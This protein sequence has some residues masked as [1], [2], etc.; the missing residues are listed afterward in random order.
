MTDPVSEKDGESTPA[1]DDSPADDDGRV[2]LLVPTQLSV[3]LQDATIQEL[4]CPAPMAEAHFTWGSGEVSAEQF[5]KSVKAAYSEVVH[6]RRN[7]F[8]V[9]SGKAGKAFVSEMAWLFRSYAEGSALESIAIT[10]AMILPPLLLQKPTPK[11]KARDHVRCLERRLQCWRDGDIESLLSEGKTIQG[12]LP[13]APLNPNNQESTARAFAKLMFQGKTKAALRLIT[14]QNVGSVL[15]LDSITS[16]GVGSVRDALLSKHPPGRPA[17]ASALLNT[18]TEPPDVHPVVFEA[19]DATT[20]KTAALRTDGAAGPSGIDARGWTRLCASFHSASTELCHSLALLARRLCS[21]YIHPDGLSAL[22]ACRLIALDKN[23]GVR[24]IGVGEIPRRIIAKAVLSVIGGEIQEAAGSIQLCSGQTSGIEAA[25]HAMK[26]AYE[27]EAVE[28]VLLVDAK[29]AFNCLNREAALRNIQHLCPSLA[30]ILINTYRKPSYLYMDGSTLLSQEGTTQGDPLAMSMYAIGIIPLIQ[31]VSCGVKQ[32]W[33]ADDATAAGQLKPIQQWWDNLQ[34]LGPDFGYFVNSSKTTLIVKEHHLAEAMKVFENTNISITTEGKQHLGAALG[35]EAFTNGF[36]NRKVQQW[37]EEV[38][39]LSAIAHTQPHAAY[40]AFIRGLSSKWTYISRTV[41]DIE[42][43]FQPLEET[44]RCSFLPT[45]TGRAP[46][47]ELERRLFALPCRLGG[48]GIANPAKASTSEYAASQ[49]VTKPLSDLILQQNPQYSFDTLEAQLIAKSNL[50]SSKRQQQATESSNLK[51]S[52][53][54]SLQYS[55]SLAQESGASS[56]L[57]TLPIEEFGFAL[58]KGAFRDALAL[59][60]GWCPAK[61]PSHCACGQPFSVSHALSCHMGGYPS[62]RHNEIRDLTAD[63]M[64]VVC[65]GVSTEPHLQPVDGEIL[66]GASA[67]TSDGARLDIAA[68]G[69][70][71]GRFERAFF[72]VRVFNPYAPTNRRLQP[73]T[74]YRHHENAKK[75]AYEQRVREIE[76]ASF[77]PLVLSVTGGLG[78]IATT[79]YKRLAS[80]LSSKWN[81][82]Y[83]TTMGWLRCRLSFALLRSSIAAIRGARSSS[84]RVSDSIAVDLV[85]TVSQVSTAL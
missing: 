72:D 6:W 9:P 83:S 68:N 43:L 26:Q 38:K 76:H 67:N 75:R 1:D 80:L 69:L 81:Q 51:S 16:G 8:S 39:H 22:L 5:I 63:L 32:V 42:E 2:D 73:A 56:W 3:D 77:V 78:R 49:Q 36:V 24:P 15:H 64:S 17:S 54:A 28:A 40:S 82:P 13:R 79:T 27:D 25:V 18:T 7:V 12:R 23:P 34:G 85:T 19:I 70:W 11:S 45:L 35:T 61:V 41:P 53:P 62:I 47:N 57:T 44:I 33:Y 59:R 31:K 48:I 66:R 14:E 52:L 46:P 84:H 50:R 10:A 65:H 37:I 30:T 29:N 74:C 21:H 71:G 55:M 58:H 4:P 60:Y 20:V